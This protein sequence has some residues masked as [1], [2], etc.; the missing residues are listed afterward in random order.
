MRKL[1]KSNKPLVASY[2]F[3]LRLIRNLTLIQLKEKAYL[4]RHH[5]AS[6]RVC[7]INR[8]PRLHRGVRSHPRAITTAP[9]PDY[10][11]SSV[12]SP[13]ALAPDA[14]E[15]LQTRVERVSGARDDIVTMLGRMGKGSFDERRSMRKRIYD[16]KGGWA[17]KAGDRGARREN[18]SLDERASRR[19][20]MGQGAI[21]SIR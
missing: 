6:V 3:L 21:Y 14:F 10:R 9:T 13:L 18:T 4:S 11:C 8:T 19:S 2:P 12:P 7:H 17:V 20:R 1:F 5:E 16:K 15:Q